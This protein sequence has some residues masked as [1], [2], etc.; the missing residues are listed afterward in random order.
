M[1]DQRVV[2]TAQRILDGNRTQFALADM[3]KPA[4][5]RNMVEM[6]EAMPAAEA[7]PAMAKTTMTETVTIAVPIAEIGL[8]DFCIQRLSDRDGWGSPGLRCHRPRRGRQGRGPW[9]W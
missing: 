1:L 4:S 2:A 9:R 5:A 7:K 6:A 3:A 8:M